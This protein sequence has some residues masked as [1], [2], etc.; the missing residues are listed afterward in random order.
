MKAFLVFV[1]DLFNF[2][3]NLWD[4]IVFVKNSFK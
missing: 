4:Q 1:F 2:L 3:R